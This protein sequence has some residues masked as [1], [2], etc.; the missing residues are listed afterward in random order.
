[1]PASPAERLDKAPLSEVILMLLQYFRAYLAENNLTLGADEARELAQALAAGQRHVRVETLTGTIAK[2]VDGCITSLRVRWQM[3]YPTALRAELSDI[4]PWQSTAEFL[5]LANDKAEAETQ[6]ALGAA[7]LVADRRSEYA[8][9]LINVIEYDAGALDLE[10][11][12]ARRL[13]LHV[14]GIDGAQSDWLAQVK[15]WLD[16]PTPPRSNMDG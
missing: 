1:M 2:L 4:G 6:I 7:L 9:Y 14:S 12:V 15:R 3:D 13:L 10:A 5:E 8:P 11:T 16:D